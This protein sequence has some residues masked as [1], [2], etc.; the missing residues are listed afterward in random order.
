MFDIQVLIGIF[1]F[2]IVMIWISWIILYGFARATAAALLRLAWL[3]PL[4]LVLVP[5]VSSVEIPSV[6]SVQPIHVLMDD[7]ESMKS[8][9]WYEQAQEGLDYL[10]DEC[11][12]L[13]CSLEVL[14]LSQLSDEVKQGYSPLGSVL[15]LWNYEIATDPWILFSDGGVSRPTESWDINLRGIGQMGTQKRGF[16]ASFYSKDM[17]NVWLT[18]PP[19]TMFSFE[20]K[21]TYITVS[22]HR[23]D[24]STTLPVQIQVSS[25]D[26]YLTSTNITFLPGETQV[27]IELPLSPLQRGTHFLSIEALPI[28]SEKILWDNRINRNIEVLPNTIG[29]LHLLGSPSWDG[30]FVRRYLKSEPKYDLISFF[31]L[32]DPVDLQLTNERELSLIPFPVDRLFN[33]ELPNFRS[34]ILQNFSLYQFLEPNYQKNLLAFVKNGGGLLFIGGP[35]ALKS[36][37]FRSSPLAAILPFSVPGASKS[38]SPLALLNSLQN[39]DSDKSGPYYDADARFRVVAAKPKQEARELAHVYDDWL[40][41]MDQLSE[42]GPLKGIHRTDRIKFKEDEYTPLLNAKLESG[43][44][45]PLVVASYPGK[46][47]ALWIFSDAFWQVAMD[48]KVSR[49]TYYDFMNSGMAWLLKQEFRKPLVLQNLSLT[50]RP[51]AA[52]FSIVV[53]GPAASYL[54]ERSIWDLSVCGQSVP[55][56][57]LSLQRISGQSWRVSGDLDMDLRAGQVCIAKLSGV[58]PSFGSVQ[59]S[60]GGQVPEVYHDDEA[61]YSQQKMVDLALLTG[62]AFTDVDRDLRKSLGDWL[63]N[64]TGTQ[65]LAAPAERKQITDYF[66]VFDKWW[67]YLLLLGVP[68]EILV[69]RWPYLMSQGTS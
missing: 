28:G 62:A 43:E 68:L 59:S 11:R 48:M 42:V 6:L 46:G 2:C 54:N 44:E 64:A 25:G 53:N 24:E 20:G 10:R 56:S 40:E 69:R 29:V 9:G 66:W 51:G 21:T 55:W 7:S 60:L 26:Q 35:R 32:R 15:P 23:V 39:L 61:L 63:I 13:G 41:I 34:L 36:T 33:E 16:I 58:H 30:R 19:T 31:I 45:I 27:D 22:A 5:E 50:S 1:L 17:E 67:V 47:R 4:V 57:Q 38:M 52:Q 8:F 3:T 14:Q 12:R 18:S 49:E 65:G 37:D